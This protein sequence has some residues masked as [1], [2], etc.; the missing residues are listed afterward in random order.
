MQ[1]ESWKAYPVVKEPV[2]A[3]PSPSIWAVEIGR[4]DCRHRSMY[5]YIYIYIHI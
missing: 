4:A 3:V 1:R 2:S 5:I